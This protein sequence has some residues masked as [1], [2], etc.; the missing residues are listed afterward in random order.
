MPRGIKSVFLVCLL[1]FLAG[2][3]FAEPRTDPETNVIRLLHVGKA[4]YQGN[5]PGPIFVQD[6]KI[7]WVPVPAHAWSMG[8]EAFRAL[9]LYLPRT[10]ERFMTG[11]DVVLI[12]GMEALHLRQDFQTWV[13]DGFKTEGVNFVMADDSSSFATSGSHTPWYFVPLGE[14]LPVDDKPVGGSPYGIEEGFHVVPVDPNHEFARNIPWDEVWMEA[15][16]RPWPRAGSTVV[17]RMSDE[18]P[19]N[20]GKVQMVYWDSSVGGGR[21]VAWIHRWVGNP[22]FWRWKYHPDVVAHVIYY[23]ARVPIPE[24]LV[25]IHRIR[26]MLGDY[27]YNRLYAMSTMDFADKFGANIRPIEVKLEELSDEKRVVDRHFVDQ[28][29]D[30][31]A[32]S[33]DLA[34]VELEE[35]IQEAIDAKDKA[36]TWIFA[37]EWLTVTGTSMVAGTLLWTLMVK[38]KLYKEVGETKLKVAG[39]T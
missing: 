35:I 15:A 32:T 2:T 9:R 27:F 18:H 12:D 24:D 10:K 11:Y 34:L 17:T 33:L 25:L 20:V 36:L 29:Y 23:T 14:I 31:A 7:N 38:R 30:E 4:W 39:E 13:V 6:P 22:E 16:N 3:S 1:L 5:A 19:L 8:A 21:S 37:I 28:E 26:E